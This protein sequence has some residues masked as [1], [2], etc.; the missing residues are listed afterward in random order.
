M[1]SSLSKKKPPGDNFDLSH[2]KLTLPD[3]DASE[4]DPDELVD[5][6]ED[7][8]FYTNTTDGSMT[9]FCSSTGGTTDNTKHPRSE[10]R[11]MCNPDDDDYNFY[12]NGKEGEYKMFYKVSINS[13]LSA[14][15]TIIGQ[16]H[17]LDQEPLLKMIWKRKSDTYGFLEAR[18]QLT[19]SGDDEKSTEL[20]EKFYLDKIYDI[21]IAV[22]SEQQKTFIYINGDEVFQFNC[23]FWSKYGNYFKAGNYNQDDDDD[24]YAITQYYCL[25]VELSGDYACVKDDDV[26]LKK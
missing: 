7:R 24:R 5:G 26:R 25:N 16:I 2:W 4:I 8:Y 23:D 15:S 17:A 6:F 3:K 12:I 14:D 11:Y 18:Y 20:V 10:L 9:F 19:D 22:N 1:D 21:L 13:N